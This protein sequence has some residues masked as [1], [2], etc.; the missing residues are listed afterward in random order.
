MTTEDKYNYLHN[1]V[2][3]AVKHSATGRLLIS[4]S[5]CRKLAK[6]LGGD[7]DKLTKLQK[8][9]FRSDITGNYITPEMNMDKYSKYK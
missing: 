2:Y 3:N 9:L 6:I 5:H 1:V 7:Y 8:F 4:T